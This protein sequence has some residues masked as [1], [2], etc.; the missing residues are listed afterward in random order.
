MDHLRQLTRTIDSL[1]LFYYD[2]ATTSEAL[3]LS[4]RFGNW[5]QA[6]PAAATT[7]ATFWQPDIVRYLV[8]YQEVTS[9]PLTE[10]SAK[11]RSTQPADAIERR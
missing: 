1:T 4:I 5:A 7:W 11:D 2:L 9:I 8:A 10:A 6:S 3:L